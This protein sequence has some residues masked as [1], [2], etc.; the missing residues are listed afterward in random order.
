MIVIYI[1]TDPYPLPLPR[2][3]PYIVYHKTIVRDIIFACT[4]LGILGRIK[5]RVLMAFFFFSFFLFP[6][7]TSCQA[8][9][10]QRPK[11]NNLNIQRLIVMHIVKGKFPGISLSL[12]IVVDQ[13]MP[14][15]RGLLGGPHIVGWIA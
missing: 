3:I 8:K 12:G 15:T 13:G 10:D 14:R 1:L 6:V 2:I 7:N 9:S 11:T 5:W 4:A